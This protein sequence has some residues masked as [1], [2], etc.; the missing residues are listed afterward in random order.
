M[1]GHM[2]A[3]ILALKGD[4]E[5]SNMCSYGA[6]NAYADEK[7]A[8]ARA[9]SKANIIAV[10]IRGATGAVTV[11]MNRSDEIVVESDKPEFE[12]VWNR[13]GSSAGSNSCS[14]PIYFKHRRIELARLEKMDKDH[15]AL[16]EAQTFQ[17]KR[18]LAMEADDAKTEKGRAKRQKRK[19]AK[20]KEKVMKKEA[21]GLNKFGDGGSFLDMMKKMDPKEM[22]EAAKQ[23][24]EQ[25]AK[26]KA[27][28][29]AAKASSITVAQMNSAQN[30]TIR[31]FDDF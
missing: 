24:K 16:V 25:A 4:T 6:T 17:E 14:Q 12:K 1:A 23:A 10:P 30:V 18:A 7:C 5:V 29:A 13:Y 2:Q 31:D 3:P 15:D 26:A 9:P 8:E 20:A 27:E 22:E 28:A 11:K 19:E 21:D